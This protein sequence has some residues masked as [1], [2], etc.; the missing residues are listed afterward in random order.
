M[1]RGGR[2]GEGRGGEVGRKRRRQG[3]K[4]RRRVREGQEES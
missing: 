2:Q 1:R 3:F 4:E